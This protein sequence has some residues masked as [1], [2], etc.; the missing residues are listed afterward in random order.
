MWRTNGNVEGARVAMLK[1]EP[2]LGG[3]VEEEVSVA[4]W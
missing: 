3:R 1:L 2:R 4:R